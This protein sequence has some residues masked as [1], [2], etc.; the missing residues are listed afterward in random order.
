EAARRA[1]GIPRRAPRARSQPARG[2]VVGR[3]SAP[4]PPGW[5]SRKALIKVGYGCNENCTFCHTAEVRHIDG[6]SDEVVRKI[7]RAAQL[8]HG[9]VVLSGGEP[10][11][12]PELM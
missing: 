1:R 5:R 9:M 10:T 2:G 6:T 4:S 11:I 3:V 12:R 8:G 7:R